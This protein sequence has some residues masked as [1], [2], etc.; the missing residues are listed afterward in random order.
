MGFLEQ[1][2]SVYVEQDSSDVLRVFRDKEADS[3]GYILRL[4]ELSQWNL[5]HVLTMRVTPANNESMAHRVDTNPV[6][7]LCLG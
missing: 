1:R 4:T 5:G 6:A 7:S 2:A 3:L